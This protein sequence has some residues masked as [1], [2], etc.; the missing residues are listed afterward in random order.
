MEHE[1]M[2]IPFINMTKKEF[3]DGELIPR[4][5]KQEQTTVVTANPEIVMKTREN[6]TYKQVVQASDYVCPD[7]IGIIYAAKLM[8]RPLTERIPGIEVVDDLLHAANEKGYACY[9]LGAE[10]SVNE[11]AVARIQEKFPQLHVAGRHHGFFDLED[12]SIAEEVA[13]T[14]PDI[15]F[16]AMGAPNQEFWISTYKELFNKGLFIG[17]GGSFDVYAGAVKRAPA[18][19]MKLNLEWLYRIIVQPSRII[20]I[21]SSI[22]F[23]FLVAIGKGK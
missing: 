3:I 12:A 16:V 20:R 15:V 1:I 8:K 9:F 5:D 11:K 13:Q 7:G 6:S 10:E 21:F 14:K 4:L 22:R 19:W 18:F 23:M 17:V 2:G